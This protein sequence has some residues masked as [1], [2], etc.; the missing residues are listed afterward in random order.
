MHVHIPKIEREQKR[1]P[2]P[3]HRSG[4]ELINP[5]KAGEK[6]RPVLQ[7]VIPL[8]LCKLEI[9]AMLEI[10]NKAIDQVGDNCI[11]II[12]RVGVMHS[13]IQQEDAGDVVDCVQERRCSGHVRGEERDVDQRK[14]GVI[15]QHLCHS[16]AVVDVLSVEEDAVAHD[17]KVQDLNPADR[18]CVDHSHFV[19]MSEI[20]DMM[21]KI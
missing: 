3:R 14:G 15:E 7:L 20:N 6:Q 8:H 5:H 11:K 12:I 4:R 10:E 2:D 21:W 13:G 9:K 19:L 1:Q 18:D 16:G 17:E